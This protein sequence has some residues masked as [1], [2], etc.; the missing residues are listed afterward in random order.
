MTRSIADDKDVY[1]ST[2]DKNVLRQGIN[3]YLSLNTQERNGG[4]SRMTKAFVLVIAYALPV[5]NFFFLNRFANANISG[6]LIGWYV[7]PLAMT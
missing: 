2:L 1:A 3:Q 7:T 5:A 4:P 6:H